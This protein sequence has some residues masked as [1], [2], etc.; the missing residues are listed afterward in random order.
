MLMKKLEVRAWATRRVLPIALALTVAAGLS[1][2]GGG[3]GGSDTAATPGTTPTATSSTSSGVITAF[4]SVFVNG[5]RFHTGNARVIDDD[6]GAVSTSATGLEVGMV[7]DVK[8]R[9]RDDDP[10]A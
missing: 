5:H 2:C 7:V 10:E 8:H 4:G 3:G 6:T 1:A 9:G